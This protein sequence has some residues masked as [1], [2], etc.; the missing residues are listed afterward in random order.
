MNGINPLVMMLFR[1]TDKRVRPITSEDS[2]WTDLEA[3]VDST[4]CQLVRYTAPT[5]V[6]RD[7]LDLL[8]FTFKAARTA[9]DIAVHRRAAE[10]AALIQTLAPESHTDVDDE[11]GRVLEALTADRWMSGLR[12]IRD[13]GLTPVYSSDQTIASL[14]PLLRYM[15]SRHWDG[16]YGFPGD[17]CRHV[18]RL[19]V[20][21]CPGEELIYDLTDLV[22][23]GYYETSDDVVADADYLLTENVAETRRIVVLTEGATDKWILERSLALLLPHLADYFTFM[24]FDGARVA[25]GAGA[26][27]AMVKAFAGAG[28]MNRVI[29][30]FDNDTAA[31]VALRPLENILTP[32]NIAILQYPPIP[33]AAR[34]PTVGP[35]GLVEMDVNGLAGS[36]ELYL[37]S[38][39]LSDGATR[40]PVQWKGFEPSVQQYQG[41]VVDKR[42]V[43]GRFSTKLAACEERPE[44]IANYDWEGLRAILS[45]LCSAFHRVDEEELIA[46]ARAG[47]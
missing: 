20:E 14:P 38:D 30:I 6:V 45:L 36:I 42:E 47:D 12:E 40:M 46:A 11:E 31:R 22:L 1:A 25:G 7:R 34:Y 28:I 29:A 39:V 44:L 10:H 8:G 41:E 15:L 43:L 32:A 21:A 4:H 5:S 27:A 23:G 33:S 13:R 9:F 35:S 19:A 18:L 3:D 17:E 37:G 24:D 16:W 2:A 26:L